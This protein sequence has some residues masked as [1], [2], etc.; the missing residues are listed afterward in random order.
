MP[1]DGGGRAWTRQCRAV[2]PLAVMTPKQNATLLK[3]YQQDR[4]VF[5][6]QTEEQAWRLFRYESWSGAP[7]LEVGGLRGTLV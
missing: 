4:E 2:A 6:A 5:H 7:G 1:V 3:I